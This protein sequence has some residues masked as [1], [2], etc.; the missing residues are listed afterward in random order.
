MKPRTLKG[1]VM[2]RIVTV[3]GKRVRLNRK[4]AAAKPPVKNFD[5]DAYIEK[6]E[7]KFPHLFK[8]RSNPTA[9]E[10]AEDEARYVASNKAFARQELRQRAFDLYTACVGIDGSQSMHND[11]KDPL[12]MKACYVAVAAFDALGD[13]FF[14][15]LDSPAPESQVLNS[16]L[17]DGVGTPAEPAATP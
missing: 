8:D 10:I 15:E 3:R 9:A 16:P 2:S 1:L 5:V 6:L 4:L 12:R 13:S 17:F 11:L 14:A 7:K